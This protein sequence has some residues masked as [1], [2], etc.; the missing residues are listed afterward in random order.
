MKLTKEDKEWLLSMGHKEC[1]LPQIEAALHTGRTT[2]SLD[3]EP[4]TRAQAL[5]LLGRESYLAGISRSAFHFTAA[6]TA[7][8]GKTIYFDSYK[9][10]Q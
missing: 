2:Y 1:N 6:Q 3:G 8:N 10:F 5:H 4:I 7:G 9:L